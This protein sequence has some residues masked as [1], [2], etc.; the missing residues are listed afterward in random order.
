MNQSQ[1][2]GGGHFLSPTLGKCCESYILYSG[3][4]LL[5]SDSK[6]VTKTDTR[7][8]YKYINNGTSINVK[9]DVE[10]TTSEHFV[11]GSR[12]EGYGDIQEFI[13][14]P[15]QVGLINSK[16]ICVPYLD[17]IITIN[18]VTYTI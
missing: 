13:V 2:Y 6:R 4:C 17:V 9:H 18:R 11:D 5:T 7:A 8:K 1:T 10:E 12:H 16:L 14:D 3:P 15:F